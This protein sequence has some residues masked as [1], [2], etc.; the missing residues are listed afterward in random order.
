MWGGGEAWLMHGMQT[1][2]LWSRTKGSISNH[3]RYIIIYN[4]VGILTKKGGLVESF[5]LHPAKKAYAT[6]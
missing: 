1:R 5:E 4:G 6:W 2:Q 3:Y